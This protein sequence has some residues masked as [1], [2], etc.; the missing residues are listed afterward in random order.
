[1]AR[2]DGRLDCA[3]GGVEFLVRECIFSRHLATTL[4]EE[5]VDS[6]L[7]EYYRP[8]EVC[9]AATTANEIGL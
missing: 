1:M 8:A 5:Q 3:L 6:V 2:T 9:L 4:S 7:R